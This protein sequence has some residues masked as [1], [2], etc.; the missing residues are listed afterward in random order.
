MTLNSLNIL[1]NMLPQHCQ[2]PSQFITIPANIFLVGV[3]KNICT[4]PYLDVQEPYSWST[5]KANVSIFLCISIGSFNL[6]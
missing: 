6:L 5:G 1:K 4:A 3:R 2:K